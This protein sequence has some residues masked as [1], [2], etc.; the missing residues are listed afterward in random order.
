MIEAGETAKALQYEVLDMEA[1]VAGEDDHTYLN[2]KMCIRDSYTSDWW[3]RIWKIV[4][5]TINMMFSG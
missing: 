3:T 2:Y 5:I 1:A 4:V